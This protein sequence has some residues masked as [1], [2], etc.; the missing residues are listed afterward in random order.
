MISS[1]ISVCCL[2]CMFPCQ[3][4]LFTSRLGKLDITNRNAAEKEK[5]DPLRVTIGC[6][7]MKL[8]PAKVCQKPG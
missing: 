1:Q 7:V 2:A 6:K 4:K 8:W 3:V 5:N